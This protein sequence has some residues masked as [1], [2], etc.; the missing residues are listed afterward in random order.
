MSSPT[1]T[2]IVVRNIPRQAG[3]FSV[4]CRL[5]RRGGG[6]VAFTAGEPYAEGQRVRLH[7]G[8]VDWQVAA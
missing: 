2:A 4:I 6:Q 5:E 7:G 3:G 1:A 8:G